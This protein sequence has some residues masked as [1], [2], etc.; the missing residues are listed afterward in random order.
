MLEEP[1]ERRRLLGGLFREH[2]FPQTAAQRGTF[3]E[4][5]AGVLGEELTYERERFLR[6]F[7]IQ[8]KT[9][10]RRPT[11]WCVRVLADPSWGPSDK[12]LDFAKAEMNNQEVAAEVAA[13][14]EKL[15]EPW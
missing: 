8:A 15:R 4:M 5:L 11:A 1:E 7:L 9:V 14:A 3:V 2:P 10:A 13:F 12:C 6:A